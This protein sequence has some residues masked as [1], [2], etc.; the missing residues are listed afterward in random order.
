[1]PEANN[2]EM[3]ELQQRMA[4]ITA[5]LLMGGTPVGEVQ[6]LSAPAVDK[7]EDHAAFIQKLYSGADQKAKDEQYFGKFDTKIEAEENKPNP[8]HFGLF[9][10]RLTPQQNAIVNLPLKRAG[11]KME[12]VQGDGYP[13]TPLPCCVLRETDIEVKISGYTNSGK[14]FIKAIIADALK[15]VG[16]GKV[17]LIEPEETT[18]I[19][20][21][22]FTRVKQGMLDFS[23]VTVNLSEISLGRPGRNKNEDVNA[24]IEV[25]KIDLL[26]VMSLFD[27][28]IS[29][30]LSNY[31]PELKPHAD[32]LKEALK[33]AVPPLAIGDIVAPKSGDQMRSGAEAYSSA[34]VVSVEPYIMVSRRGDMKWSQQKA[35]DYYK[36]GTADGVTMAVCNER[37][38]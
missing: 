16:V 37:L 25:N 17:W 19:V 9:N 22:H 13:L 27:G 3:K 23:N 11:T 4:A 10:A 34:V 2:E 26:R 33:Q 30:M 31:Y 38:S 35:E 21:N 29:G 18:P 8:L 32:R 5:D 36:I 15:N 20:Q 7:K 12:Y 28:H 6:T 24:N 1:M 14:T